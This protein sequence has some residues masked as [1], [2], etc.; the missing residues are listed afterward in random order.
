MVL[1]VALTL[2]GCLI[3]SAGDV[4]NV[5]QSEF[6]SKV[7][8]YGKGVY[9][10]NSNN[11]DFANDLSSFLSKNP[12]LEVSAMVGDTR[13]SHGSALGYFVTFKNTK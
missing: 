2:C 5:K 3:K 9:Y 11:A 4:R 12:H 8:D 7:V 1:A 10:F 6:S 13:G